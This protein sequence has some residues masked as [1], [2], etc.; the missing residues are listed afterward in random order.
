[1]GLAEGEDPV[2]GVWQRDDSNPDR[3]AEQPG[4]EP[5]VCGFSRTRCR[6]PRFSHPLMMPTSHATPKD[7]GYGEIRTST[8]LMNHRKP[9][10]LWME[11]SLVPLKSNDRVP[12]HTITG[13][14]AG[15]GPALNRCAK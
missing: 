3:R 4:R 1:M 5:D 6:T 15:T 12:A 2:T 9:D 14:F 8:E 10:L 11:T 13:S 7:A